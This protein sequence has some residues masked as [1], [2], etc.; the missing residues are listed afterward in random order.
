M[1]IRQIALSIEVEQN[2]SYADSGRV[3]DEIIDKI[4]LDIPCQ[5]KVRYERRKLQKNMIND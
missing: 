4:I 5:H 2:I 1:S 3:I